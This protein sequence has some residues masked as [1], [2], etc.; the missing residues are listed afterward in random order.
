MWS[1]LAETF[2]E[3]LDLAQLIGDIDYG[4]EQYWHLHCVPKKNPRHFRL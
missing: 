4:G 3:G 2:G 1:N